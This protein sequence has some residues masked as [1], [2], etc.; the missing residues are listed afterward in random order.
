MDRSIRVALCLLAGALAA[1]CTT[2]DQQVERQIERLAANR[3]GSPSWENAVDQLVAI[4]RPAARQLVAHLSPDQY[5][6]I[7]YREYRDEQEQIRTGA[8]RALGRIRPRGAAAALDDRISSAYTRDE[9]IACIWAIG[10]LGFTQEGYDACKAQLADPDPLIRLHAAVAITK[11]EMA[12][13]VPEL[14]AALAG[15][16]DELADIVLAG[17]AESSYAGVPLLVRLAAADT[18]RQPQLRAV[19]ERVTA[20][21]LAA[22]EADDPLVR[23]RA[24]QALGQLGDIR[25]RGALVA[26]LGDANTLVRFNAAAALA[27]MGDADGIRFLFAALEND[28]PIL[29][30]NAVRYLTEVQ[31]HSSSVQTQLLQALR[32]DSPLA[33]AGSAQVLG[34]A[35]VTVALAELIEA[36]RDASPEVR[37]SAAIALGKL[38]STA[39]VG[40]LQ[41]LAAD[42][43][44][45][46]SYYARWALARLGQ[47]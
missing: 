36:T 42:P 15:E 19:I 26:R 33:R 27:T 28:D 34:D 43:D 18:P 44:K 39:S 31:R 14:E 17:L 11:M 29:R 41:A 22:V 47:G 8:A 6:G 12:E 32:H 9:R 40:P 25:N 35:G 16:A 45:T 1:G 20:D 2:T 13:G 3:I 23:R 4:G 24:A 37:R 46:V 10:Q 21:L 7:Y 30:A 5:K 38:G